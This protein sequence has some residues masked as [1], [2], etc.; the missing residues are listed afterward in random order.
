MYQWIV[1]DKIRNRIK[2]TSVIKLVRL[3]DGEAIRFRDETTR[4]RSGKWMKIYD[5]GRDVLKSVPSY[6]DDNICP[7]CHKDWSNFPGDILRL[8]EVGLCI[9]CDQYKRG[10]K[11]YID[12]DCPIPLTKLQYLL[13]KKVLVEYDLTREELGAMLQYYRSISHFS[14]PKRLLELVRKSKDPQVVY[15][16]GGTTVVADI[17]DTRVVFSYRG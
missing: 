7:L 5:P 12:F 1:T 6:G 10:L 2:A 16:V 9:G 3:Y 8:K 13:D 4:D 14:V 15:S 11:D 17:E